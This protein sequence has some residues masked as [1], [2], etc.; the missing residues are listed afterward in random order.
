MIRVRRFET[1]F[2]LSVRDCVFDGERFSTR[3]DPLALGL[4]GAGSAA[5]Y[6]TFKR[7]DW[8]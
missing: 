3:E 4:M 2:L 6:V 7:K 8:L 1:H 5:L